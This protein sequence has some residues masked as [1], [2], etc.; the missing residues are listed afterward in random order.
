[1]L[2]SSLGLNIGRR[3]QPRS[4]LAIGRRPRPLADAPL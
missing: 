3:L 1:M 2:Q 4:T